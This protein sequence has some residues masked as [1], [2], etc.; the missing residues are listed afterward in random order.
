LADELTAACA[1]GTV[2]AEVG[3]GQVW[4]GPGG[5]VKLLDMPLAA[6]P[7]QTGTADERALILLREIAALALESRSAGV[8]A[9]PPRVRLP[10]HAA[11]LLRRLFV[12][13]LGYRCVADF[14]SDLNAVRDRPADF[15]RSRR[16]AYTAIQTGLLLLAVVLLILLS[17]FLPSG[18][19]GYAVFG[20]VAVAVVVSV[21][22][23]GGL[24]EALGGVA[25]VRF[26]G[27]PPRWWQSACRT[28]LICAGVAVAFFGG[29][30]GGQ[31]YRQLDHTG[32]GLDPL[33][34]GFVAIMVWQLLTVGVPRRPLSNF[35]SGTYLVPK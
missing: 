12:A 18:W 1:D 29:Q 26:D 23:H 11:G 24:S 34:L 31:V 13:E 15:N 33:W 6:G 2:P 10:L 5:Q 30:Y 21:F 4:V 9:E 16:L 28:V 14:H 8:P 22:A 17:F 20:A 7:P 19:G 32:G 25:L 35:L 27:R 3:C